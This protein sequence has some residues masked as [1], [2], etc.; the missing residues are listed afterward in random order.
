MSLEQLFSTLPSGETQLSP[1]PS[2]VVPRGILAEEEKVRRAPVEPAAQETREPD[3]SAMGSS[4][5]STNPEL[6]EEMWRLQLREH[7]QD[8]IHE[9]H[10]TV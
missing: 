1:L 7:M 3:A 5:R 4:S 10:L 2:Q 6:P 9:S 8:R